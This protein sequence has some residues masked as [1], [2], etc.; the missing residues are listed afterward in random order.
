MLA[1]TG[2]NDSIKGGAGDDNLTG[3]P[4]DDVLHGGTGNDTLIDASGNNTLNGNAGNDSLV[5]SAQL[6]PPGSGVAQLLGGPG[7]DTIQGATVS[8]YGPDTITGGTE[9]DSIT[10]GANDV[11]LDQSGEDTV[12]LA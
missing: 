9:A 4:G 5:S 3:G 11:I 6:S 10:A 7:S 8:T 1:G 12:V 2:G